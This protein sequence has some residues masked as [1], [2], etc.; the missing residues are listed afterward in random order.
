MIAPHLFACLLLTTSVQAALSLSGSSSLWTPLG[1]NF[2]YSSDQQ[3]GSAS[4]DIVGD[5]S[6]VGFFSAFDGVN[7]ASRTDGTLAFRVRL[8]DTDDSGGK[9]KTPS[10]NRSAWVGMDV[11]TD[12]AIDLFLG[13]NRQGSANEIAIYAPDGSRNTSPATIGIE[14]SPEKAY[15]INSTNYHYRAVDYTYDGG[16]TNDLS[17]AT[18]GDTDYYVSFAVPFADI[19]SF[20]RSRNPSSTFDQDTPVQYIVF[21]STQANSINQDLGGVS[22]DLNSTS[23]WFS[24]G[25]TTPRVSPTGSFDGGAVPEPSAPMLVGLACTAALVLR[26]RA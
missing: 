17:P 14:H 3:T 4:A 18:S 2:D 12:G 5:A 6:N 24:L 26:R 11:D 8:D 16:T 25:A 7:T 21:T 19:V 22:G 13:V 15:A 10:F 1:S 9:T 23:S 20:V